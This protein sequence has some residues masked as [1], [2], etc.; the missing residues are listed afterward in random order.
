MCAVRSSVE[1]RD[2]GVLDDARGADEAELLE[3]GHLLD[4]PR[5]PVGEAQPPAGH[6]VGLAE[7]VDHQHV[8]VPGRR[9]WRTGAS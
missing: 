6:A 3:L 1:G 7:A 9:R 4:E 8:L 5:R 2:A